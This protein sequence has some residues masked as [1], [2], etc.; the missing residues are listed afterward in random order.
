MIQP[1]PD[2]AAQGSFLADR[3][4][5]PALPLPGGRVSSIPA[6]GDIESIEL[7][8]LVRL[9]AA[10]HAPAQSELVRRYMR[11][12]SGFVRAM[13]NQPDAIEDVA[14]TVFIKMFRQ[15][16]RLRDPGVFESWLFTLARN[17]SLDFLRRRR[18]RPSTVALDDALEQIPDPT[19]SQATKEI[20][21]A[22]DRA[23]A[24][25]NPRD[26]E[27]VVQ[28][29]GGDTYGEI[30]E[31]TGLSLASV[32]VRLHRVRP[33]LRKCDGEMTDTRQPGSK[34]W[35]AMAGGGRNSVPAGFST[36]ELRV[37]A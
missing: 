24:Q 15:L 21:A 23:L 12:V 6:G 13:I 17:A 19:D 31:R 26:R 7:A 9:A 25:L 3:P 8:D 10:D 4:A 27:L 35:R 37:A 36:R 5:D 34:G 16:S 32:K 1:N 30:A 33:F 11:R 14:Q 20:L 2:L 28:F 29:V 22:L 18:C